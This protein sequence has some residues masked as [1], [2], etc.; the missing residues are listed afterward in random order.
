MALR[1]IIVEDNLYL[2]KMSGEVNAVTGDCSMSLRI[3]LSGYKQTPLVIN[4]C[5]W[6]DPV[7]GF[8]LN[9]GFPLF[10]SV[11]EQEE[12]L[13]LNR[14]KY[15]RE[16]IVYGKTKGWNGKNK[17]EPVDGLKMLTDLGYDVSILIP[18]K[19]K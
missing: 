7:I 18:K 17:L 12:I 5:S 14:P 2:Y 10:N 13:N 16:S 6:D 1:R 4:F 8:P 11:T 15:I 3:F 9:S 19:D